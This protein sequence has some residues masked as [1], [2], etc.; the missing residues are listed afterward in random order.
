MFF[1]DN[2]EKQCTFAVEIG[3]C[4]LSDLIKIKMEPAIQLAPVLIMKSFSCE[5]GCFRGENYKTIIN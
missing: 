1:M 3:V 5:N 4:Q 2:Q